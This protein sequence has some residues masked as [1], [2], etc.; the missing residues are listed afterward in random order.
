MGVE[1]CL[2]FYYHVVVLCGFVLLCFS[3]CVICVVCYLFVLHQGGSQEWPR[4]STLTSESWPRS[5]SR[6]CQ[7]LVAVLARVLAKIM[8]KN[9]KQN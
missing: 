6:S 5:W 2:L 8:R 1:L 4:S 3:G 7:I 9:S